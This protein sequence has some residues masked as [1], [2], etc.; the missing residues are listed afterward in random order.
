MAFLTTK[1]HKRHGPGTKV[2][3]LLVLLGTDFPGA[4]AISQ[5]QQP[6][7]QPGIG[8]G[9]SSSSSWPR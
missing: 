5:A 9:A 7:N 2:L 1:D 6:V 4:H 3:A 8:G